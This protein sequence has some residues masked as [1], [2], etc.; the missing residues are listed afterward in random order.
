MIRKKTALF[1]YK[2]V[3]WFGYVPI[4]LSMMLSLQGLVCDVH[5]DELRAGIPVPVDGGEKHVYKIF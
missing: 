3:F 2:I 5:R 1:L 4:V